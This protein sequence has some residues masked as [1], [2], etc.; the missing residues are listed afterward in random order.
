MM[1]NCIGAD[2]YD[3]NCTTFQTPAQAT[4]V[5]DKVGAAN[6][7]KIY[8]DVKWLPIEKTVKCEILAKLCPSRGLCEW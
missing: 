3:I 2:I 7:K 1:V 4:V 5:Y 8:S 6:Q